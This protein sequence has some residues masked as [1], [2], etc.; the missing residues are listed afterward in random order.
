MVDVM[1]PVT[2]SISL[3]SLTKHPLLSITVM[4]YTPANKLLA[5]G[6]VCGVTKLS[7]HSYQ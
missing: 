6:V 5:V 4:V 2:V 1:V 7:F 3:V